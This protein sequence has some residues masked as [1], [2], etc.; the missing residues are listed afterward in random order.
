ML[1]VVVSVQ[2]AQESAPNWAE[3]LTEAPV[4]SVYEVT[5]IVI[6]VSAQPPVTLHDNARV[7]VVVEPAVTDTAA[8]LIAMLAVPA[9][10]ADA[11]GKTAPNR[12]T[13]AKLATPATQRRGPRRLDTFATR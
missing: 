13:R 12:A 8:G 10:R 9:A 11:P 7:I 1:E 6:V 4:R 2:F 5:G 3:S